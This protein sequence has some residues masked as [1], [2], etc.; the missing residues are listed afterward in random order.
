MN[1]ESKSFIENNI[2]L[3]MYTYNIIVRMEIRQ[4]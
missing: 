2:Y 1:S 4:L 3:L